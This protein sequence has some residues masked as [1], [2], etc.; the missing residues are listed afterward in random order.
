MDI[1][2]QNR[3]DFFLFRDKTDMYK[4]LVEEIIHIFLEKASVNKYIL[5][6]HRPL[7]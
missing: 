1:E 7:P 6:H 2:R 5:S 4:Y 3:C